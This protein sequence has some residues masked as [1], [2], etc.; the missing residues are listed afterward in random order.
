MGAIARGPLVS[1]GS[2]RVSDHQRCDTRHSTKT[3]EVPQRLVCRAPAALGGVLTLVPDDRSPQEPECFHSKPAR[4]FGAVPNAARAAGRG[5]R[6]LVPPPGVAPWA[7]RW[8]SYVPHGEST[9][10]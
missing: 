9:S 4:P 2:G 6:S 5:A 3:A 1:S 10:K 7:R 8:R